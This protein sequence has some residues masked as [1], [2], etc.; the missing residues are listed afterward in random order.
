[1]TLIQTKRSVQLPLTVRPMLAKASAQ[2]PKQDQKYAFEFKWDGV[3]ALAFW[4][5]RKVRLLSRSGRDISHEFPE[6][7]SLGQSLGKCSAILDGEIVALDATGTPKFELLQARLGLSLESAQRKA[8]EISITFMIFDLL[9]LNGTD[10][11]VHPLTERR[12][13]LDDLNPTGPHWRT[14]PFRA[15]GG[16][17]FL[18]TS[19]NFKLEGVVAKR[20]DSV[21]ESG[22][23][24]GA[25]L[26]IK[27]QRRAEFLICGWLPG[28]G[29]RQ[30][31]IGSVLLGYYD[32]PRD[33]AEQRKAPQRLLF[34]GKAGTGFSDAMLATLQGLLKP[35]HTR[36]CPFEPSSQL[37]RGAQYCQPALIGEFE[38]TEWTH[39][40]SL[41]HPSFKGLRNDK[42]PRDVVREEEE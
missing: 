14:S 23:R 12:A 19:R 22:K 36:T 33:L 38:F 11:T 3:R 4:D 39:L 10:L 29:R 20:L 37:P 25:W 5:E 32:L 42:D 18:E 1:M 8:T 9:H 7:Q 2:L 17:G 35:L 15:G 26:K 16:A 28:A 40:N 27:N 30:E 34:A 41:R 24:T 13:A 31:R 21:Y 6:L